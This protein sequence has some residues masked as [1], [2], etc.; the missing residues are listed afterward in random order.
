MKTK[1]L[2]RK[3]FAV[4]ALSML[5]AASQSEEG[6]EQIL[7]STVFNDAINVA[8]ALFNDPTKRNPAANEYEPFAFSG[9]DIKACTLTAASGLYC[10]DEN[11]IKLARNPA[12]ATAFEE[13]LSCNEIPVLASR[14]N[15]ACSTLTVG[16]NKRIYLFGRNRGKTFSAIEI[17]RIPSTETCDVLNTTAPDV[18]TYSAVA[19]L[20]PDISVTYCQREVATGRPLV[21][22]SGVIDGGLAESFAFA[23]RDDPAT[24][25]EPGASLLWLEERTTAVAMDFATETIYELADKSAW[26]LQG[27]TRLQDITV[28]QRG[29]GES[30]RN[31]LLAVDDDGKIL[32][33]DLAVGGEATVVFDLA[34]ARD[35]SAVACNTDD[36]RYS[37]EAS[38]KTGLTF[39]TDSQY[40]HVYSLTEGADG[41]LNKDGTGELTA[42]AGL[43]D[44][45]VLSTVD[46]SGQ[47]FIAP[48]NVSVSP[49]ISV[50]LSQCGANSEDPSC[51]VITKK[52]QGAATPVFSLSGV[53]LQE[54]SPSGLSLF[55]I[56]GMLDCR[57]LPALC[58]ET[59]EVSDTEGYPGILNRDIAALIAAGYL[60]PRVDPSVDPS[61]DPTLEVPGNQ[62]LLDNPAA[63]RVNLRKQLPEEVVEAI[64]PEN[65]PDMLLEAYYRGA[66]QACEFEYPGVCA[67]LPA[68]EQYRIAALFGRTEEGVVFEGTFEGT[69]D[70]GGLTGIRGP[71]QGCKSPSDPGAP[72]DTQGLLEYL[73]RSDLVVAVSERYPSPKDAGFVPVFDPFDPNAAGDVQYVTSWENGGCG[74]TRSIGIGWTLKPFNLELMPCTFNPDADDN[75][76]GDGTCVV[77]ADPTGSAAL[78]PGEVI[79][80]AVYAKLLLAMFDELGGVIDQF[81]CPETGGLGLSQC[82]TLQSD[83]A[84]A[85]DKLDKCWSATQ[86]PKTSAGNQNC[87]SFFSQLQGLEA[88]AAGIT[89]LEA[90]VANRIGEVQGRIARIVY[91]GEEFFSPTVKDGGFCEPNSSNYSAD[92]SC[93][94][95]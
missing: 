23:D 79:D 36:P 74:S 40:C 91:I 72:P 27:K 13:L 10:L 59:F 87:Q 54:L 68:E 21:V 16:L 69:Y 2:I 95:P 78:V 42:D 5:A 30:A 77:P 67:P 45:E 33:I 82:P 73:V 46:I 49:G 84:N 34:T 53:Q 26:G 51:D 63:L 29:E 52:I 58:V 80:D 47:T 32:A 20:D 61:V 11:K 3:M 22:A 18:R 31:Y 92:Q 88:T 93:S 7:D 48:Q 1:Y 89:P 62:P 57:F 76:E 39:L 28:L 60:V 44:S 75:W 24:I 90:D 9:V 6:A 64:G 25:V 35:G 12:R 50:D 70:V 37:I 65:L 55:Q 71:Q 81:V 41:L 8:E 15:D 4:A 38:S 83:Y 19:D 17:V 85:L 43:A 66:T 56:D 94:S 14:K 86:Q